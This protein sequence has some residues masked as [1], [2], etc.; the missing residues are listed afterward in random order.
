MCKQCRD[1]HL[2]NPEYNNH[3]V[4]LYQQR[5]RQL[6][7]EKCNIH[8]NKDIDMLCEEYQVPLCS[9]CA[10]QGDHRGHQ[11]TDLETVYAGRMALCLEEM[12]KVNK[13]FLPTSQGLQKK[14]KSD[15]TEIKR[16][17]G[18][19]RA[20]MKADGES[21][22]SLVDTVVSERLCRTLTK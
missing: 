4:V 3:E 21:L 16:V 6:P 1:E 11:F 14:I 18:S 20:A 7:V 13:Y 19:L 12:S 9:K 15:V 2:N 5:K 22:K 17:M 8:P 10:T